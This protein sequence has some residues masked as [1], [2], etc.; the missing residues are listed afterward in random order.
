MDD[1]ETSRVKDFWSAYGL[2][3]HSIIQ[4]AFENYHQTGSD[5]S[6]YPLVKSLNELIF[7]TSPGASPEFLKG[8]GEPLKPE[9]IQDFMRLWN[10]IIAWGKL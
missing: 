9:E 1:I 5:M 8:L 2:F 6:L 4:G 10:N 3:D 7:S